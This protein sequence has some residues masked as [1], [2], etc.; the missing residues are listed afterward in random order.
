MSFN[1]LHYNQS[2]IITSHSKP[3]IH[4]RRPHP[5]QLPTSRR[6]SSA[7]AY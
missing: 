6:P 3:L 4:R 7:V 2:S 1:N 5:T